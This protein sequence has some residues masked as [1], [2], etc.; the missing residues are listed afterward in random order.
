MHART[1]CYADGDLMCHG[2]QAV[3]GA[4]DRE[5]LFDDWLDERE[6][7][8]KGALPA[9]VEDDLRAERVEAQRRVERVDGQAARLGRALL[10]R[11]R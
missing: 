2:A 10:G 6:R 7:A 11:V 1:S 5:E 3:D 9:L 8:D 4:R